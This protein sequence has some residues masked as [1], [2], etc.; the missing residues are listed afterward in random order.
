M[1][2][3]LHAVLPMTL[4]SDR[5][6]DPAALRAL[7]GRTNA[8]GTVRL[9]VHAV[10]LSGCGWLVAI[11]GPWMLLPAMLAFG[12]VQVALFAPAHETMHQTAFARRHWREGVRHSALT[13]AVGGNGG[14][15]LTGAIQAFL[16]FASDLLSLPVSFGFKKAD[17]TVEVGQGTA[18][19]V[20]IPRRDQ[21][22]P[23]PD[24][25]VT[26]AAF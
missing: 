5:V 20:E 18:F 26:T 3:G 8:E 6:L 15:V 9:G 4:V 24:K 19:F 2:H 21:M 17:S 14:T 1:A 16:P 13:D 7:S 25:A 11:A 22:T 23:P 12:I 10:L